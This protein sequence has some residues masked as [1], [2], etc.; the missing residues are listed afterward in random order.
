MSEGWVGVHKTDKKQNS[1]PGRGAAQERAQ[2][3]G[4]LGTWNAEC[5]E[6][7]DGT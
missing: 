4:F 3:A 7:T 5:W 1:A 2:T 6:S